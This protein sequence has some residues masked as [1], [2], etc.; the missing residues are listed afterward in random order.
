MTAVEKG[1]AISSTGPVVR[2]ISSSE[3][4]RRTSAVSAP[5]ARSLT[6]SQ[7]AAT[8]VATSS[9]R[10]EWARGPPAATAPKPALAPTSARV[11]VQPSQRRYGRS[12]SAGRRSGNW[13]SMP[14]APTIIAGS[15][16]N[17]TAENTNGR[18]ETEISTQ[19][20]SRTPCRSLT[21]VSAHR[22]STV[23]HGTLGE[24]S[25][26]ATE[27]TATAAVS[28]PANATTGHSPPLGRNAATSRGRPPRTC[29]KLLKVPL[30]RDIVVRPSVLHLEE[31]HSCVASS[32]AASPS[33][34]VRRGS[35]SN[36]PPL[37]PSPE[38]AASPLAGPLASPD[39]GI[40]HRLW[41]SRVAAGFLRM[42]F[43]SRDPGRAKPTV[44]RIAALR[45]SSAL[46][47]GKGS[48]SSVSDGTKPTASNL[49]ATLRELF[50]LAR[51]K[52]SSGRAAPAP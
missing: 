41:K 43:E 39:L 33:S 16:P 8:A 3:A 44:G 7:L 20:V 45:A 52:G 24:A 6:A 21:K 29:R 10:Y 5:S 50:E 15:G 34:L 14:A 4:R 12:T 28:S 22:P 2:A 46:T 1:I 49:S 36:P 17:S 9:S 27:S 13:L 19:L 48:G 32:A 37:E 25:A 30:W 11:V 51:P 42:R 38:R 26:T 31:P 18:N 47:A 40:L 35:G 23:S